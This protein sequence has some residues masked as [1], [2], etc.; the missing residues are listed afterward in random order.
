V[1]ERDPLA[2]L[3]E[4]ARQTERHK[5]AAD[6]EPIDAVLRAARFAPAQ[7]RDVIAWLLSRPQAFNAV[8][9]NVPGPAEPLYLLG[10]RVQAAYPAVPLAQGHG[11]S[12]GVLSYCG[13][14]NVGLCADREIVPDVSDLARDFASAFD[15]LR[16]VLDPRAPRPRRRG[17]QP[18]R[19][20]RRVPAAR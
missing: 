7:V 4:V 15:A 13:W 16:Q 14:L 12:I 3:S 6:A 8:L 9:S 18:G 1:G 19:R 10:R 11:L 2:V 17:P 20:V 5:R